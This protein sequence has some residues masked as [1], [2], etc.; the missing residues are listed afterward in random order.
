MNRGAWQAIVH[1]VA[2]SNYHFSLLYEDLMYY[3]KD[4]DNS[5]LNCI[6]VSQVNT[7]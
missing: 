5:S 3:I 4:V 7:G 6:I 1:G 2:T